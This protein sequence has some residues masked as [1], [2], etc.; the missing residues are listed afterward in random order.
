MAGQPRIRIRDNPSLLYLTLLLIIFG[1]SLW[2]RIYL[3]Y[4]SILGGEWVRFRGA[5]AWYHMRLVDNMLRHF[6]RR[7]SFDPYTFYPYGQEV[8]FAPL[9]DF[10]IAFVAWVIGLGNPGQRLAEVVGAYIPAVLGALT[11]IPVYVLGKELFG[12]KAGIISAAMLAVLP[13]EFLARSLLGFTDHH[14]AESFLSTVTVMFLA[15]ALK[16][17]RE[18]GLSFTRLFGEGQGTFK[19]P[20]L[21]S[22]LAGAALASYI[23]AWT[24]G[25]LLVFILF[26]HL[27]IQYTIAHLKGRPIDGLC[28]V[29]TLTFLIALLMIVPFPHRG[30][31]TELHVP[32][33]AIALLA[34]LT[35]GGL[36][37][38]LAHRR[39]NRLCYPL[40]LVGLGLLGLGGFYLFAPSLL[41]SMLDKFNVFRPQG[42]K[43]T[44]GEARPLFH[45]YGPIS[46]SPVSWGAFT[47][48]FLL[49]LVALALIAYA[50]LKEGKAEE[51]LLL[52]WSVVMLAAMV[53]QRRFGYY[54][55]VNIALLA[56]YFCAR[57]IDWSALE[58]LE[59]MQILTVI[60][61]IFIIFCPDVGK[62]T[63]LAR[64]SG[65]LTNIND[66]WY[67]A[68]QWL[69]AN[70]P[71]PFQNPD[72]YYGLYQAP[73]AGERYEYP[74][75]AY[76]VMS[77]WD[78]GHWITRIARRIPNSNPFGQRGG[79]EAA[80]FF[81]AQDESQANEVLEKLGSKY[82][83]VDFEMATG[84]FPAMVIVAGENPTR[85][86]ETYYRRTSKGKLVP[87]MVYYP[88]YYRSMCARL[89]NFGG[90]AVVPRNSTWVISYVEKTDESGRRYKEISSLRLFPTY[91][92]AKA[93]LQSQSSP[94][95][96][97]VGNDPFRSP[98]PLDRLESYRLVYKSLSVVVKRGGRSI[99]YVEVFEYTPES[100]SLISPAP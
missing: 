87:V 100:H 49:A 39:V 19:K 72:F 29:S 77:W 45:P 65:A 66:D 84:K 61:V 51:T 34:T 1:V 48:S 46:L 26:C 9:F 62:V 54:F 86:F 40:A 67:S 2:V 24:A 85:F 31:L 63:A 21:L 8:P 76:G 47:A 14:S 28:L 5:D 25:L 56:G 43:L 83:I 81:L 96:R 91:E 57:I 15:L 99:S 94:H 71:D 37:K 58:K 98:V 78:Y 38:A 33:L 35:L 64:L 18:R 79:R 52:V 50:V 7:I 68:L 74:D 12:R 55:D 27:V 13:G 3:P 53:S 32:A 69:R 11:T 90:Q 17:A 42:A 20:L 82:V 75:S 44:I 10:I 93:Y 95:Y 4:P 16:T 60:A 59:G 30:F 92:E 70:T 80:R 88:A 41:H 22:C 97:I 23:L 73:Q 36:S 89:Y 6:P